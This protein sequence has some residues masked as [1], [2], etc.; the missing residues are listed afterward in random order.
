MAKMLF[1][2][3]ILHL[4]AARFKYPHENKLHDFE[5]IAMV[6]LEQVLLN[7]AVE[8]LHKQRPKGTLVASH[9]F[10]DPVC[11]MVYIDCVLD[12]LFGKDAKFIMQHH[13]K[14]YQ[15]LVRAMHLNL[16]ETIERR[17]CGVLHLR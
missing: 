5:S 10:A 13:G 14:Y 11:V 16:I 15:K 12:K 7:D 8:N 9:M 6:W 4:E 2:I 17:P 3:F 1:F